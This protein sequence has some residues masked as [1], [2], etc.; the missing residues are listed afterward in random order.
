MSRLSPG[1]LLGWPLATIPSLLG[2]TTS[3]AAPH[4]PR[5]PGDATGAGLAATC[6]RQGPAPPSRGMRRRRRMFFPAP[7]RPFPR[8][9]GHGDPSVLHHPPTHTPSA[10]AAP[11]RPHPLRSSLPPPPPHPPEPPVASGDGFVLP[12][13]AGHPATSLAGDAET[14]APGWPPP[15]QADGG[16]G[17]GGVSPLPSS[18]P[19]ALGV[20][21]GG[22]SL[23]LSPAGGGQDGEEP[24][25]LPRQTAARGPGIAVRGP[26]A[27]A[28]GTLPRGWHPPRRGGCH[29]GGGGHTRS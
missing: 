4:P 16:V 25:G 14:C 28:G 8:W 19:R 18:P 13:G 27:P 1:S 5:E 21:P 9:R 24:A 3:P 26:R 11:P 7:A 17:W 6:P 2:A 10:L 15:P 12:A 20:P 29:V 22:R 23:P